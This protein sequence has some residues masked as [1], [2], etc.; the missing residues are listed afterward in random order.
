M[1]SDLLFDFEGVSVFKASQ[2]VLRD[3]TWKVFR[4]QHWAIV[5]ATGSGK[6]T[7]LEAL[8]GECLVKGNWQ[9]NIN[10]NELIRVP[11]DFL[12]HRA[13]R[14]AMQYYQQ[15]FNA[16]DADLAP[17][18]Y[19]FLTDTV[20]PIGTVND[21]SVALQTT[22]ISREFLDKTCA[23]LSVTHLLERR[24]T[25]LSNGET[26]RVLLT[27]ALLKSPRVLLLDNP[28]MGLD[29]A[30][31]EQLHGLLNNIILSGIVLIISTSIREIPSGITHVLNLDE[32]FEDINPKPKS[33]KLH[34]A[35]QQ[36]SVVQADFLYAVSMRNI[37]VRYGNIEILKNINWAVKRGEKWAVLGPNGSGKSTLLSLITA[38]NP[39]GY[40]ND[41]DLFDKKRG[42]GE[43]IWDIKKRIGYVSPEL[44][45]YFPRHY[46]CFQV[47]A[48]G[49]YERLGVKFILNDT[50]KDQTQAVIKWLNLT[51]LSEKIFGQISTGQQRLVLLA[52]A[53]VK[54]PPLLILDEPC[55]GL[56]HEQITNFKDSI[57]QLCDGTDRTLIYVSHYPDEIPACV[58]HTLQLG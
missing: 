53:L 12:G 34:T 3:F 1:M 38:D 2:I 23:S 4:G 20:K 19:D 7:L 17:S 22:T 56:D 55:Q 51:E 25:S 50:A 26:R 45:S 49:L 57:Q 37:Q 6:T 28:F 21:A 32:T 58:T 40:A 11:N 42:T 15:R 30:S 24:L 43:S 27:Y 29:V 14:A 35:S 10:K 36:F 16:F 44:Q 18:V 8:T 48:S 33:P 46:S 9:K 13:I 47:V 52:R 5:G 41:Y 54:N 31:R 39:Q